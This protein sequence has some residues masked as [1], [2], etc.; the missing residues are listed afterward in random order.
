MLGK[1]HIRQQCKTRYKPKVVKLAILIANMKG[2]KRG[3][4]LPGGM[5]GRKWKMLGTAAVSPVA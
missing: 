3:N 4:G 2:T 1:R 5:E